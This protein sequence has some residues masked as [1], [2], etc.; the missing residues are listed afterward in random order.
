[1]GTTWLLGTALGV[2]IGA[3]S[4]EAG[5]LAILLVLPAG[6][7][8]LRSGSKRVATSGLLVGVGAGQAGL[9]LVANLRCTTVSGPGYFETCSSLDLAPF[10]LVA[11]G[12]AAAGVLLGVLVFA[13]R[14]A[15]SQ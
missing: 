6:L 8:A 5:V 9:L 11:G 2:F 10:V 7:W 4:L 12:F 15:G 13:R 14:L 1:M 3:F